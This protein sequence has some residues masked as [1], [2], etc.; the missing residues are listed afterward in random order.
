MQIISKGFLRRKAEPSME[1]NSKQCLC[2]Q[3]GRR[4]IYDYISYFGICAKDHPTGPFLVLGSKISNTLEVSLADQESVGK[5][6]K[7]YMQVQR[8]YAG[9]CIMIQIPLRM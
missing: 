7:G 1:S 9:I 3:L 8:L 4:N 2:P 5:R 6:P